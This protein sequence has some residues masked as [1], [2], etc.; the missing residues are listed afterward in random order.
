MADDAFPLK[1]YIQKPY[2][3]VG[4]TPNKR[5]FNY[6]LSRA[7]RV[8]DNAF[9]ILA[10]RF[11]VFMTPIRLAPEKVENIVLACCSLHNFLSSHHTSR[12][13]YAPQGSF[14]T[15][16]SDSH[17][18][19]PGNWRQEQQPQ[20]LISLE[21]RSGNRHTN[22]AKAM[23]D[24]CMYFNSDRGSVPWQSSMI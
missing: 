6:M 2:S 19:T 22:A 4:L 20:G 24:L 5:I 15:E 14:D 17:A 11:R 18:M 3:Q 23:R 13:I 21:R 9:G 1:E 8:V 16:D 12:A 10:N 7:R